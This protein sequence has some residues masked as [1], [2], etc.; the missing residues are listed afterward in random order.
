MLSKRLES[1]NAVHFT[2]CMQQDQNYAKC[3]GSSTCIARPCPSKARIPIVAFLQPASVQ[4]PDEL[5]ALV[6]WLCW[7]QHII[8]SA[9]CSLWSKLQQQRS[10]TPRRHAN[11]DSLAWVLTEG[12]WTPPRRRGACSNHFRFP[13]CHT[14]I[15]NKPAGP[16]PRSQTPVVAA[17]D[18]SCIRTLTSRCRHHG[19]GWQWWPFLW[20][21]DKHGWGPCQLWVTHVRKKSLNGPCNTI[22]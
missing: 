17:P 22:V 10:Y 11:N 4:W 5:D 1:G 9:A 7:E 16:P 3:S 6:G 20:T 18:S 15:V 13:L 21:P 2:S 8:Y 19:F 12:K 14:I